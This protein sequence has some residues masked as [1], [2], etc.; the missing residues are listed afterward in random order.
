MCLLIFPKVVAGFLVNFCNNTEE[1]PPM[2]VELNFEYDAVPIPC[3]MEEF[4][5][6]M[7]VQEVAQVVRGNRGDAEHRQVEVEEWS[8]DPTKITTMNNPR[9]EEN[10]A[11][12]FFNDIA[13]ATQFLVAVKPK[14]GLD[15]ETN[16]YIK[17]GTLM[18]SLCDLVGICTETNRMFLESTTLEPTSATSGAMETSGNPTTSGY[19]GTST[20][21]PITKIT[22]IT[23]PPPAVHHRRTMPPEYVDHGD[24]DM[25]FDSLYEFPEFR[26][27]EETPYEKKGCQKSFELI[28]MIFIVFLV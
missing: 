18:D 24:Y 20:T 17:V 19:L 2:V 6:R 8:D 1:F 4:P 10:G 11:A 3:L 16:L 21:A 12:L 13:N 23:V 5:E 26:E 7:I 28:L 9:G 25:I 14:S 27:I 15:T 22:K